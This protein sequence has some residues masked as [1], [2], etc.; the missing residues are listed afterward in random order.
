MVCDRKG[1][2]PYV[3]RSSNCNSCIVDFGNVHN[4]TVCSNYG[5]PGNC[6]F[7]KRT[8][9]VKRCKEYGTPS[10]YVYKVEYCQSY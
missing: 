6:C 9:Q 7:W 3:I 10:Y 4:R 2:F 1:C 5:V 8:I